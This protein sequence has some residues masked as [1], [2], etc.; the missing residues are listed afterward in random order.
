MR[1]FSFQKLFC[2]V[3]IVFV[4]GCCLFYGTR[5]VKLYLENKK[6]ED[7]E[8][9][10]LVKV[11]K[12]SNEDNEY[13]KSVN[14]ENYFVGKAKNNYLWYSNILWRIMKVNDDNSV[15]IVSENA[16]SS[17]AYGKKEEFDKSTIYKWLNNTNEDYSGILINSLN[18]IDKYLQKTT[19]C[20]D[21]LD[22]LTNNPCKSINNDNYVTLLSVI[23]YLNIGSKDSYL[24]NDEF[25]YLSNINSD[26]KVWYVNPDGQVTLTAGNDIIGIRPVITIMA[27]VDYVSGDGTEDKPYMI[28]EDNGLFGSYVKLDNDIW[29]IYKVNETEVRL[30][31]NDYLKV[32][33]SALS[34]VYS[35]NT[36][37]HDDTK[38]GSIAYYLNNTY[39][40][41][42]S[43]K[44]K[45][46]EVLWTNGYYNSQT[47]YD[48]SN[49][50]MDTINTKVAMIS[51]GDIY[52]NP[53]LN[54]YFT[55]TGNIKRG[56]S[57]YVIQSDKKM[58]MKQISSKSNVVPTISL[59]K[60][61]LTKGNGTINSPYEVE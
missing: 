8:K 38:Y 56:S 47:E 2:F 9:N 31:L 57:V 20:I 29:R 28:E 24:N 55:L 25:F 34:Y 44:D 16:L 26:G 46:K 1:K 49:A 48:Y 5:F 15:T 36:S 40:N 4:L 19:A 21:T 27:N 14:G 58:Y 11:I 30:M 33:N 35:N 43:Y 53:E 6:R 18:K 42:L 39:L 23:D 7:I 13:F 37:Y 10:T 17:L 54:N 52:L 41:S 51:I 45:I 3:S 50:L 12:D 60:D 32:N 61:L 59:D 22:E